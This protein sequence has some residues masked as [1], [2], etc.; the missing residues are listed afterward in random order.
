MF[1]TKNLLLLQNKDERDSLKV[2]FISMFDP[3]EIGGISS[4]LRNLSCALAELGCEVHILVPGSETRNREINGILFHYFNPRFFG[5]MGH[6]FMFS[7]FSIGMTNEICERYG[8]DIVHGQSPSSFGYAL[9]SRMR[10][11][12]VVTLH[13]TSFGEISST[14]TVPISNINFGL[15]WDAMVVQPLSAVLTNMEY[16]CADR[17]I[18]VSCDM[19]R[20]AAQYYRL[21]EGKIV[22]I[23]NGVDTPLL[24]EP[25]IDEPKMGHTILFVGRLVWR[26]GVKYLVDALPQILADYGDTN[27]VVVGNGPEKLFLEKR[28]K[29]LGIENSVQFLSNISAER[30]HS[31]YDEADIYVQPSLYEPFSIAILE[32]MSMGKPIVTTRTGGTPE[33]IKNGLEGLLVEPGNSLHLAGAIK[34]VFSDSSCRRRL[35]SNARKKVEREF[36]WKAIAKKTLDLYT[37]LLNERKKTLHS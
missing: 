28:I 24:S 36:T 14:F 34:H 15:V 25:P 19:A 31:L 27:I 10:R 5:T 30:L 3:F 2:L 22:A 12:Y 6:G 35:G 1:Q 8:I 7:L 23:H 29:E 13:G 17:V 18:A 37:N 9:L 4:H 20:E 21:P 26:K 16:R 32:A 33:L 11:P